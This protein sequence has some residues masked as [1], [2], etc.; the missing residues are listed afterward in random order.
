MRAI[1]FAVSVGLVFAVSLFLSFDSQ[2]AWS[3]EKGNYC[4]TCHTNARKLIQITRE[5]AEAE[6]GKVGGAAEPEGAG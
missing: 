1:K 2:R 5:I 6:K 4:F 3:V